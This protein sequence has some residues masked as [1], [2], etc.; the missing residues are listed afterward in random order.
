MT[1]EQLT[2]A[3]NLKE[4]IANLE[5]L[6]HA[7]EN[8]LDHTKQR[9]HIEGVFMQAEFLPASPKDILLSYIKNIESA[10]RLKKE[11]IKELIKKL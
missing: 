5:A 9:I 4:E 6:K 7:A 11:L 8:I 2:H 1:D 10:I 3:I